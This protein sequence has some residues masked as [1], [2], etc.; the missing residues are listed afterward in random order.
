MTRN[1]AYWL[2]GIAAAIAI[3][4]VVAHLQLPIDAAWQANRILHYA[5]QGAAALAGVGGVVWLMWPRPKARRRDEDR[6]RARRRVI[7]VG[8]VVLAVAGLVVFAEIRRTIVTDALLN[9]AATEDL[10][11][12]GKALEAYKADHNGTGPASVEE[13][14]PKYLD[15]GRLWY[16]CRNGPVAA[17]PPSPVAE[18]APQL[19]SYALAKEL[20]TASE[21]KRPESRIVAY[22]RPGNAWAAM[23]VILDSDGRCPIV[24]EDAVRRF[25]E[26]P[27]PK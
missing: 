4:L 7:A 8:A 25:E 5:W 20:P 17:P 23:T 15:A 12:I 6:Q 10:Q 1:Q 18:G 14:V 11:A 16:A 13:L 3:A 2:A 24:G 21:K 27:R 22:L 9:G 19:S 26:Q